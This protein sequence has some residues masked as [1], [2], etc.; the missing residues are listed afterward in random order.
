MTDKTNAVTVTPFADEHLD[1]GVRLSQQA[2]WPHRREDWQLIMSL[3]DGVALIEDDQVV[4]TGFTTPF[5]P[6]VAALNMIIVAQES[7][8][9]GLGRTIMRELMNKA[10][11]REQRLIATEAGM[12]LYT[13]LGFERSGQIL[14]QQGMLSAVDDPGEAHWCRPDDR[15]AIVELDA[16]A[17]GMVRTGLIDA[18]MAD[19]QIAVLRDGTTP[20]GFAALRHFGRGRTAGPVVANNSERA[21]SL[22]SFLFSSHQGEFMRVDCDERTGLAN[23]LERVGL[24][25]VGGGVAMTHSARPGRTTGDASTYA[26]ASQALG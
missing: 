19:G 26:L 22:L 20:T 13:R 16:Q 12:R 17:S 2:G 5:G 4:A 21:R 6:Q 15:D 11:D 25:K 10:G 18:L 3:S 14:Q 1:A 23:W 8:G 9:R 24:K 7:R